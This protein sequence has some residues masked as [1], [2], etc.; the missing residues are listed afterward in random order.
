[1][2]TQA[3]YPPLDVKFANRRKYCVCF[4]SY[5]RDNDASQ[6]VNMGG[7]YVKERLVIFNL[8]RD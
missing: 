6:R 4:Q 8:L 1:M 7:D 5:H 3:G 2:L